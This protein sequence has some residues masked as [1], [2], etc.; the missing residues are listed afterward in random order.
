MAS[1]VLLARTKPLLNTGV[2]QH[3][4]V[5]TLANAKNWSLC[6]NG[7]RRLYWVAGQIHKLSGNVAAIKVGMNV[8]HTGENAS[9]ACL[10]HPRLCSS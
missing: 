6:R 4:P 3:L 2:L 8:R 1:L 5:M 10:T 9:V 7:D